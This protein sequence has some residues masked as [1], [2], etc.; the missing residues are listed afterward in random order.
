VNPVVA[1]VVD[2]CHWITPAEPG[3]IVNTFCGV[4]VHNGAALV[5]T[6]TYL[7]S[8]EVDGKVVLAK[9]IKD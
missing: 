1:D 2:L 8:V 5:P 7:M 4:L 9:I 3:P 6:G